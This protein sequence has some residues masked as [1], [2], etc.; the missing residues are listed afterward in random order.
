[1]TP[2]DRDFSHDPY[3]WYRERREEGPC[4]NDPVF[5]GWMLPRAR[6]VR[7]W[8][9]DR[10]RASADAIAREIPSPERAALRR[11]DEL[12]SRWM[13]FRD[14]P[15]H[16]SARRIL[17]PLPPSWYRG[18]SAWIRAATE[19]VVRSATGGAEV[20]IVA[21]LAE[22]VAVRLVGT[23]LFRDPDDLVTHLTWSR[24]IADAAVAPAD[25][26]PRR[27]G[28]AA[29]AGLIDLIEHRLDEEVRRESAGGSS[30]PLLAAV[31]SGIRRG[32]IPREDG[33]AQLVMLPFAGQETTQAAIASLF[34]VLGPSLD[35]QHRL[36]A[37]R[38]RVPAAID[39]CLR[40]ESPVQAITRVLREPATIGDH[41][42]EPGEK[43]I[44]VLGS[45]HR[46]PDFFPDPDR[47]SLD[48]PPSFAFG[49]GPHLCWGARPARLALEGVLTTVLDGTTFHVRPE[50]VRWRPGNPFLRLPVR[51]PIFFVRSGP[52]PG[53]YS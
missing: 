22:P 53:S 52:P 39:E 24:A 40:L 36:R 29:I 18:A 4:V 13:F 37:D 3:P 1:M 5:G 41:R 9:R 44:L 51:V 8:L 6:E 26:G 38:S 47:P 35:L 46:D 2:R 43:L 16:R 12:S 48:R 23:M 25:P 32:D 50:M 45:A 10:R 34:V 30:A 19:D 21:A 14:P 7:E 28:V 31:A 20:D 11:F 42:L 27:D 33:L 17:R 15:D 49:A